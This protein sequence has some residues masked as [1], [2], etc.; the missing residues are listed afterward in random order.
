MQIG[1]CCMQVFLPV[2]FTITLYR[3]YFLT[4]FEKCPQIQNI[5]LNRKCQDYVYVKGEYQSIM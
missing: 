2:M 3:M 1:K 5:L 4:N